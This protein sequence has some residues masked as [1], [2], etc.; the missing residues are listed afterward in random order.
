M[1][2]SL[3]RILAVVVFFKS[4]YS[5]ELVSNRMN[6]NAFVCF[7]FSTFSLFTFTDNVRRFHCTKAIEACL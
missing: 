2:F 5:D 3:K 1:G 6:C 7:I 4:F